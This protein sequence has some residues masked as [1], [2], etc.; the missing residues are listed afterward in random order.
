MHQ[1]KILILMQQS[2]VT[3]QLMFMMIIVVKKL[4]IN[5]QDMEKPV[6]QDRMIYGSQRA[7]IIVLI[8]IMAIQLL[9]QMIRERL[10]V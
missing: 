7:I 9:L 2:Q 6:K 1:V 3:L 4:K 10:E 5:I 8:L